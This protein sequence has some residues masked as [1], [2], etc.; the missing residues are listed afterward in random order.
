MTGGAGFIGSHI[1]DRLIREGAIVTVLDNMTNGAIENITQWIDHPRFKLIEKDIRDRKAVKESL[2]D[3]EIVFHQAARVSVPASV[4]DPLLTM[5][6]N[7]IGTT[8][9]LHECR[10]IGVEK[11]VTA[12]SSSVYGDTPT[13]PKV[14]T[15]NT[16]PISP[17]GVSKLAEEN[18]T[19]SFH[20]TYGMDTT[21]LRYFN[22]YG[23]RQRGGSYAGVISIFISNALYGAPLLIEGDGSQTRDFT[24]ISDVVECNL[25]VVNSHKT[26]GEVYNVGK[27]TQV[28]IEGLADLIISLT[29]SKSGKVYGPPRDGDVKDSLASLDKVR[30]DAGFEP[31][32]DIKGG[33]VETIKWVRQRLRIKE[34]QND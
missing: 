32:V 14:E 6:V 20:K 21:A 18:I 31:I 23:P 19:Q 11:V 8:I 27:G 1:V 24:F 13:L 17:Y 34:G 16:N 29:D 12:S 10:K 4:K 2:Q 28:T 3:V 15:M 30:A 5:D 9:L 25:L 22:V 26:A 7:V 33:L